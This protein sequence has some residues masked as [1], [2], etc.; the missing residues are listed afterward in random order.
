MSTKSNTV[1]PDI[2]EIVFDT[3]QVLF[4]FWKVIQ[5][6]FRLRYSDINSTSLQIFSA[7]DKDNVMMMMMGG[8][9]NN[10]MKG[11]GNLNISCWMV[12]FVRVIIVKSQKWSWY[13][14]H[15]TMLS[16]MYTFVVFWR[17]CHIRNRCSLSQGSLHTQLHTTQ[18]TWLATE[19]FTSN[20]FGPHGPFYQVGFETISYWPIFF[21]KAH[22]LSSKHMAH[23]PY[24]PLSLHPQVLKFPLEMVDMSIQI[25][26]GSIICEN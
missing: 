18:V 3:R 26:P 4:G 5:P 19:T 17:D 10:G 21:T 16:C 12:T 20:S 25:A 6:V 2:R 15:L 7:F 11:S 1:H 14:Y 13:I 24:G 23:F 9:A 8:S 22:F